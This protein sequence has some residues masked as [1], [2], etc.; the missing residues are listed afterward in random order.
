MRWTNPY[1]FIASARGERLGDGCDRL[2]PQLGLGG[3]GL[4]LELGVHLGDGCNRLRPQLLR[5]DDIRL[6]DLPLAGG[7]S[8]GWVRVVA[9]GAGGVRWGLRFRWC[10]GGGRGGGTLG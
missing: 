2:R 5:C 8:L 1:S 3:M 9:S 4:R 6:R 10:G 7:V